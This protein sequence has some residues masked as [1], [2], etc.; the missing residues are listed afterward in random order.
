MP[1]KVQLRLS[2]QRHEFM[3]VEG[4][5]TVRNILSNS[6]FYLE[7]TDIPTSLTNQLCKRMG[8]SSLHSIPRP[9]VKMEQPNFII[10]LKFIDI[11]DCCH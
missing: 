11:A 6:S 3:S 8:Y 1:E 9:S 4:I 2:V 7:Y 5:I 10:Q